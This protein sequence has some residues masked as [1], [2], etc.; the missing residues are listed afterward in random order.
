VVSR[1]DVV[2]CLNLIED[3]L[4][5]PV[6]LYEEMKDQSTWKNIGWNLEQF[7]QYHLG[8]KGLLHKVKLFPY[9]MYTARQVSDDSPTWSRGHYEPAV[10]H[11][12]KYE[13]EFRTASAYATIIHSRAD[14]EKGAWRQFDP[15][16][17][18][19]RP[20]SL[21]RRLRYAC[22]RIYYDG[23]ATEKILP[24]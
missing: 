20:V 9:V 16:S 1:A 19:S 4:L 18:A 8:R 15:K 14:W 7:L 23:P 13:G 17:A 10:G 11:F 24:A 5:H 12:I 6:Q 3:I 2:N 22:E 21:P